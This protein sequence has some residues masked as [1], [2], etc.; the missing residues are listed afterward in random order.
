MSAPEPLRS[1]EAHIQG[2][3][4]QDDEDWP[5]NSISPRPRW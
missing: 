4:R 3:A 1:Y 2:D 5:H